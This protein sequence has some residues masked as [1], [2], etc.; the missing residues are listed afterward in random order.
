VTEISYDQE[1]EKSETLIN[2]GEDRPLSSS[3]KSTTY[4]AGKQL[5][6]EI[7]NP[8]EVVMPLQFTRGNSNTEVIFI[9]DLTLIPIEEI[10]PT[11]LVRKGNMW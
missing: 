7:G 1:K 11:D 6:T 2:K 9:G 5:S 8:I 10:P 4:E 3:E